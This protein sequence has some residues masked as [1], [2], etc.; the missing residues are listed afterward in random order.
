LEIDLNNII[1][2]YALYE[3]LHIAKECN[4]AKIAAFGESM[5]IV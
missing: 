2:A 3:R 5:I 4:I 1:E